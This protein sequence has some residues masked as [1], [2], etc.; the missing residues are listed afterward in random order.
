MV[1]VPC[2][3]ATYDYDRGT[4]R[5][6]AARKLKKA[7]RLRNNNKTPVDHRE[8][9]YAKLEDFDVAVTVLAYFKYSQSQATK[10]A[11]PIVGMNELQ[12]MFA[13]E[14]AYL[15]NFQHLT[16]NDAGPIAG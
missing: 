11:G 15:N 6:L 7:S 1:H 2:C 8:T 13:T 16:T 5:H 12:M 3:A 10:D 9:E 4:V 14:P